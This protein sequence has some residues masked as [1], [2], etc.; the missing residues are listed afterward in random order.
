MYAKIQQNAKMSRLVGE[1]VK[2]S[3]EVIAISAG[4]VEMISATR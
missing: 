2:L 1:S 3:A 4:A